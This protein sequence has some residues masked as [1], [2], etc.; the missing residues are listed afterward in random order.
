MENNSIC[1]LIKSFEF[2]LALN[3][4]TWGFFGKNC[5]K[6][7]YE[8]YTPSANA[9]ILFLSLSNNLVAPKSLD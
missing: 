7:V 2:L 3:S 8:N 4:Y 9:V 6:I 1:N 5:E